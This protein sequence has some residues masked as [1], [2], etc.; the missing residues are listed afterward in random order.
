[1]SQKG[2]SSNLIYK[3]PKMSQKG[4]CSKSFIL[5]S[6]LYPRIARRQQRTAPSQIL[7]EDAPA[8]ILNVIVVKYSITNVHQPSP[9]RRQKM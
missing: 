9:W 3:G 4:R 1:M 5:G 7:G 6:E 8:S 2:R